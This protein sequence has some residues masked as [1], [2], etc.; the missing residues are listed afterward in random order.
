MKPLVTTANALKELATGIAP[1]AIS[2]S[3]SLFSWEGADAEYLFTNKDRVDSQRVVVV[4]DSFGHDPFVPDRLRHSRRPVLSRMAAFA[5]RAR[6]AGPLTLPRA[7]HQYK[8]NNLIAFF[9][10]PVGDTEVTRWIA[11]VLTGDRSDVVFWAATTSDE[12]RNL[13]EFDAAKPSNPLRNDEWIDAA[14]A[15][16]QHF[17]GAERPQPSDVE[18]ALPELGQAATRGRTY[19]E[20]MEVISPDQRLFVLAPT[21]KSIRLRGPAG[22]GKTLTLTLKAVHEL[23]KARQAGENLRIL[24]VTHSWSLAT[25]ISES[26]EALGFG[27]LPEIEVFPLLEIAAEI[28]PGSNS[29]KSYKL[30]G[31]DSFSGK[32]AQL[33][34]ILDL[35]NDFVAGDWVTYRADVTPALRNRFDSDDVDETLALAW[36]LLIEF[37]SVIGAAAI[38]PGAGAESRYFSL[39]RA[40]WMLPLSGRADMRVVFELYSRYME[41]LDA[42]GL[43][44]S[45]Q[46]LADLLNDLQKHS[47]NR[48]RRTKGYDLI[49]VDE[50]HLFN[51]LERQVLHYLSRD[52]TVY[53]RIFMA[54]DPRQSPSEA[55][56]GLASDDT[57]SSASVDVNDGLGEITSIELNRVHRYTPEILQLVKHVH[58]EFPT[59]DLGRDWNIDFTSVESARASGTTPTLITSA[60]RSGEETDI[61][62]AVQDRYQ[63]GTMALAVVDT[64]QW[65]RFSE[66]ASLIGRSQKFHVATIAGR[67]DIKGLGYRKRGLV[68]GLA[69]YLAGLQFDTVLVAGIPDLNPGS[70]T[71]G[72]VTRLLSLLYLGVSRAENDVKVFVNDDDGGVPEVL[73]RAVANG[74]MTSQRGSLV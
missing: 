21:D 74:L 37:G 66:L 35:L 69:E 71:A 38:F 12:K 34:E 52:V 43:W 63:A 3:T 45:D 51:P 55:F 28:S 67:G 17:A 29:D 44:T 7:W 70:R 36:D 8:Y 31:N 53:P 6:T 62:R 48:A 33:D 47:W 5:E 58:L 60:S 15:A 50:F 16:S 39:E 72:E 22:S 54:L 2:T 57:R 59:L 40:S 46:V 64:R 30:I 65:S 26:S 24:M 56:I 1:S 9:A 4:R 10:V 27:P 49:F 32:Q 68:V 11:E 73:Q 25:E 42:R 23:L 18:I 14:A 19:D 20:W 13:E 41:S 61:A